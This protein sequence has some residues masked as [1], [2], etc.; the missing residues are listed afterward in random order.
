[1]KEH[2]LRKLAEI[3]KRNAQTTDDQ[4]RLAHAKARREREDFDRLGLHLDTVAMPAF[5]AFAEALAERRIIVKPRFDAGMFERAA[6]L[7][8]LAEVVVERRNGKHYALSYRLDGASYVMR[9]SLGST[10]RKAIL[11]PARLTATR[12]RGDLDV[13]LEAVL[14]P[15]SSVRKS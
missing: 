7:P 2:F 10:E 12:L 6:E 15:E 8:P 13:L 1:M 11:P 4:E 3:E 5:L 9:L 14:A